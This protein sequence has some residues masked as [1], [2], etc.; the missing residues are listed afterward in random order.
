MG[1][2]E[3]GV[4]WLPGVWP[5]FAWLLNRGVSRRIGMYTETSRQSCRSFWKDIVVSLRRG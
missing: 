5:P 1:R 2:A 3:R 4:G